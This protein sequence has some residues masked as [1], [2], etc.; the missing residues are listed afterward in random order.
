MAEANPDFVLHLGDLSYAEGDPEDWDRWFRLIE[1]V[2]SLAPYM[3]AIGNH[4]HEAAG[5]GAYLERLALPGVERFYSFDCGM[6]HVIV[7][8]SGR[9]YGDPPAGMTDWLREDLEASSRRP[10][11]LWTVVGFHFPPFSSGIYGSWEG[12]RR[13]WSPLFDAYGVNLVLGGHMHAYER[14]WPVGADGTVVRK[15]YRQPQAPVYVVTGG[16]GRH[17]LLYEFVDPAPDWSAFRASAN[18]TLRVDVDEHQMKV[19]AIR[20][21][22]A[23]LDAF[24]I[25]RETPGP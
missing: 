8:D 16:A 15:D 3:T 14:S 13:A 4:E 21:N 24:T 20:P 7:L 25:T 5:L 11:R 9:E 17:G 18:H 23:V 1:P 6:L 19:V 10:G 2:A 22:G 12:G